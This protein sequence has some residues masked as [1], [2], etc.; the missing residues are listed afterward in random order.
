MD[1]QRI[2]LAGPPV[3]LPARTVVSLSMAVHELA[4]NASKY[5]A[6]SS[7]NG[8]V[9]VDWSIG[10]TGL[11]PLAQSRVALSWNEHNGPDI[12]A[13][14]KPGFGTTLIRRVICQDLEG[15]VELDFTRQ[16]LRGSLQFPLHTNVELND[17]LGG[18]QH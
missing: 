15:N 13:G 3:L 14:N 18:A 2:S 4:T 10:E 1:G 7:P 17:L 16:G 12:P 11:K 9:Q 5:G 8:T 6:L